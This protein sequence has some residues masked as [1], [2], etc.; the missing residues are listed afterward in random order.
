MEI[1]VIKGSFF[2]QIGK[3]YDEIEM[4]KE[5]TLTLKQKRKGRSLNANAYFWV[6]CGKLAEKARIERTTVYRNIV[7][8]IG[9]N[10]T[11]IIVKEHA[12]KT[13]CENWQHNGLGWITDVLDGSMDGYYTVLAYCGSSCYDTDQMARLIELTVQECRQQGIETMTPDEV[14]NLVSLW[15]QERKERSA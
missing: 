10:Y 5:Y 11:P 3:V 14:A 6:L 7:R 12:V 2:Q 13:F 9:G 4:D 1:E 8:E 15:G